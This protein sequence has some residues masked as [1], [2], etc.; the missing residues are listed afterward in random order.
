MG[1]PCGTGYAFGENYLVIGVGAS[2]FVIDG[3]NVGLNLQ[4]WTSGDPGVVK[5]SPSVEYFFYQVPSITPYIGAFYSES[6]IENFPNLGSAGGRAGVF[7]PVGRHAH[8]G[9]GMAYE[10]YLNCDTST[11]SSCSDAYPE[12]S[13]VVSF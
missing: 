4:W 9:L 13:M 7:L 11:Y 8:F 5:I 6:Y 3:L 12:V 2:Y 10:V 1:V